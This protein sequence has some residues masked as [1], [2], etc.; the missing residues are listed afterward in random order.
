MTVGIKNSEGHIARSE[1]RVRIARAPWTDGDFTG[2]AQAG[3][4]F[5]NQVD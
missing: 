3:E 2:E 1:A 4:E 5:A